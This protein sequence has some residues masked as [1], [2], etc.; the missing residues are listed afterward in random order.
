MHT[1]PFRTTVKKIPADLYTP[2]GIY[3][4]I[5]DQFR[6]SVLLESTDFNSA[7]NSYSFIGINAIAGFE[8]TDLQT[9]EYRLPESESKKITGLS[10]QAVLESL[11]KFM[12][13]FQPENAP[14][15]PFDVA[16]GLLGYMSYNAVS[17]FENITLQTETRIPVLRFRFYRYIIAVNHFKDEIYLIENV[18]GDAASGAVEII[19]LIAR[20]DVPVFPFEKTGTEISAITDS[21]YKQLVTEGIRQCRLGN[22]F[23]VVL[24]RTFTQPFRGD[25]FTVYRALRSVN[26]GPY[27]F[28]F[29]YGSYRIMGSSPESQILIRNRVATIHPIAGTIKRSADTEEDAR[30]AARLL[31]DPKENAEHT[32]L[33]DLARNDLSRFCNPVQIQY[34]KKLKYYSHLIH[35]VSEVSGILNEKI[36]PFDAIGFAF[37]AGTLS[38]AP[39][40]RAMQII[41]SLETGS[42]G[43]YGG[44]IGMLGFNGDCNMA[45]IIRSFLSRNNELVF[46]AGAGIVAASLPENELQEV[47]NKVA[48]LRLAMELAEDLNK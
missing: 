15:F 2:V 20:K 45:I 43:F 47:N 30:Q 42:R 6:D 23:Q 1:V 16:Q 31:E 39:K 17:L 13:C 9:I 37:P 7:E 10:E 24:S 3:L 44:A 46:R 28:Y 33:V 21:S 26:P 25:D 8:L 19:N 48:A 35:M 27:L 11:R 14:A 22:V 36:N 18:V 41:D 34:S 32:M 40:H 12:A 4:R 29:D 5:R 38:G